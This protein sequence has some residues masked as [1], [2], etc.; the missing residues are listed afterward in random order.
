MTLARSLK[1]T[2]FTIITLH[3]RNVQRVAFT[4]VLRLTLQGPWQSGR[5]VSNGYC[6]NLSFEGILNAVNDWMHVVYAWHV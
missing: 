6:W 2:S 5:A 3:P 1:S 4:S